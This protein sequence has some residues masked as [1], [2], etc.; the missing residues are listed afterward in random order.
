MSQ[1]Q[2]EIMKSALKFFILGV[3]TILAINSASG[4]SNQSVRD[5]CGHF[6]Q[7]INELE[8]TQ[9]EMKKRIAIKEEIIDELRQNDANNSQEINS[10]KIKATNMQIQVDN[11]KNITAVNDAKMTRNAANIEKN[12]AKIKSFAVDCQLSDWGICDQSCGPGHQRRT[13]QIPKAH[14]GLACDNELTRSCK[15]TKCPVNCSWSD[16]T[17]CSATCGRGVKSRTIMEEAKFGGKACDGLNQTTCNL[18]DCWTGQCY[19]CQEGIC[20]DGEEGTSTQCPTGT[21]ACIRGT[22]KDY[23][24]KECSQK[25]KLSDGLILNACVEE[26]GDKT[27]TCQ[28]DNCNKV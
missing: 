28:T 6:Q 8:S 16:W 23:S 20:A 25:D 12:E 21:V 13:I 22:G 18:Q 19:E 5:L 24:K 17:D 15:G 3:S 2:L 14:G 27:C 11:L 1:T 10:L 26:M 7:K 9:K 4:D